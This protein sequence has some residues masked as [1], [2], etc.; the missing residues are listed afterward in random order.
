[1]V[2]SIK[3][4]KKNW[5]KND[6]ENGGAQNQAISQKAH[7]EI[8]IHSQTKKNGRCWTHSTPEFLLNAV[9]KNNGIY[10]VITSFPHKLYFDIDKK[11]DTPLSHDDYTSYIDSV[12]QIIK[13]YFPNAEC[14]VSGSNAETKVSLHIILNNYIISNENEREAIKLLVIHI[15][16]T[17]SPDFDKKVYTKNRNMKCINQ[18]KDDGRIQQICFPQDFKKHM[19]TCFLPTHPIPLPEMSYEIKEKIEI[20]KAKST[21]DLAQ[22]PKMILKCPEQTN[23]Y[24][25]QPL[26]ILQLLPIS[27]EFPHSYTHLVARFCFSNNIDFQ[28]FFSWYSNKNDSKIAQQKW[29]IHWN[30]L[31]NFPP[32]SIEKIKTVL[33]NYYP[34]IKKDIHYRNFVQT[35][36]LPET[37]KIETITQKCFSKPQKYLVFNVGMGGGKTAQTISFLKTEPNFLWIAPNKALAS[38]THK[39][40]ENEH[41]DVAHYLNFNSKQKKIGALTPLNKLIIVLNSLHYIKDSTFDVIVIDEIETLLDKFLGD[42]MEQGKLQLKQQIWNTFIHILRNAKKVVFLDAFITS[43]TINFINSIES[44]QICIFERI[45]EP[46]TRTIKYNNNY[47]NMVADIV[48]KLNDGCK[49]FIFY[50]YK[51]NTTEFPSME[52]FFL[53]LSSLTN[54]K[55]VFYNADVDDETKVELRDVNSAWGDKQ[56]IITNNIITCGVNYE[57]LDFD[58]KYIFI[59]SFNTPRDIIQVSYR[60]RHLSTGIIKICYCGKMIQPNTWLNDCEKINCPIYTS[61]YKSILVEKKAPLKRSFQ[62]FCVKAHY[63]QEV[64][65]IEID[66]AISKEFKTLLEQQQVGF[67][68]SNIEDIDY[69]CAEVLQQKCVWQEATMYEKIQLRKYYFNKQF[70]EETTEEQLAQI[71]DSNSLFF[72]ERM[73]IILNDDHHIFRKIQDFNQLPTCFPIDIKKTKLNDNILDDIFNN[74]SF[75][76]ITKNSD[77]KKILKEIYNT[78]FSKNIIKTETINKHASYIIDEDVY[79]YYDLARTNLAENQP[80][81]KTYIND[82]TESLIE[83]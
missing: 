6:N 83:I 39:R 48:S 24:D 9:E 46:Q 34:H 81:K 52:K 66:E 13:K 38:N 80:K 53:T 12:I 57:N 49:L 76:T 78:Y 26:D 31:N 74:F 29:Q 77:T 40:F 8:V 45:N 27:Q 42:F 69:D 2:K 67:S 70:T 20:H 37:T 32:C 47:H 59:A 50:P 62:L 56:F 43:K 82:E 36:E 60:A 72:F 61:L 33:C 54:A 5:F 17:E 73:N 41:L 23:F 22:L 1:M 55:G 16:E 10:E 19:I 28:T 4:L 18:S 79:N 63:K 44:T 30:R 7:D 11:I 14:A 51:K 35:F 3:F 68:Y 71:W 64:D 25:L 65:K 58:Y 21:F 15:H 75:R